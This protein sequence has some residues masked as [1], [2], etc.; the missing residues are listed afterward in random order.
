MSPV[1]GLVRPAV[2]PSPA[3]KFALPRTALPRPRLQPSRLYSTPPPDAPL[4]LSQRLKQMSKQYGYTAVGVYLA[5]SA[6]DFPFCF[7]AVRL[8][9]TER[10]GHYE[11]VAVRWVKGLVGKEIS[12]AEE[13]ER[14][15]REKKEA[16]TCPTA[17]L[18][19]PGPLA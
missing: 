1:V 8:L 7:L 5:L 9:G 10:V 2:R 17:F 11:E 13:E 12:Q 14:R 19:A 6:L 4:S 15:E 3:F 18:Y 16:S